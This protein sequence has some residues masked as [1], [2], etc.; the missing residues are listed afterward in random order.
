MLME[1]KYTSPVP[2]IVAHALAANPPTMPNA[3]G[4][5]RPRRRCMSSR[6][7]PAKNGW[8][9]KTSTGSVMRRLAQRIICA[10]SAESSPSDT[11]AGNAYIITCM[12][13]QPRHADPRRRA[14]EARGAEGRP[15]LRAFRGDRPPPRRR[16][17]LRAR[18]GRPPRALAYRPRV[19]PRGAVA[20]P[21][22]ALDPG[23]WPPA[24]FPEFFRAGSPAAPLVGDEP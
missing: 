24:A 8:Q 1:S 15:D 7:A 19:A 14:A 23:R 13:D 5:S 9:A 22:V 18:D 6:A 21:A 20:R 11:Y 17:G 16:H 4:V 10:A 2:V 3:I 12:A